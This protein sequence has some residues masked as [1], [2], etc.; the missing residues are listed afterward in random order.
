MNITSLQK[1]AI[2]IPVWG[3][4][5]WD[6]FREVLLADLWESNNIPW[7]LDSG[8]EVSVYIYTN[9]AGMKNAGQMPRQQQVNYQF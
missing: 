5:F 7:L 6:R 2:C 3:E 1:V 9:E 4:A 8:Y